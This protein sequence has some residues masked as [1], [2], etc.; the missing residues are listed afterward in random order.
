[1]APIGLPFL[2]ALLLVGLVVSL[3]IWSRRRAR[4]KLAAL[5]L[6]AAFALVQYAALSD[7]LSRPKPIE[8]AW[9]PPDPETSAVVAN[10]MRE[11]EAIFIWLVEEG[12]M[13]PRALQLP[14]SEEMARQLHEASRKSE[15][16]GGTLR[17][18][19]RK[20]RQL[21]EGH[22]VF[23]AEPQKS[24]PPKHVSGLSGGGPSLS[25]GD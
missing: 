5:G 2:A 22:R 18:R 16:T 6:L 8:L 4:F 24:P 25:S 23:Y 13:E 21:V 10:V 17:M 7:L 11:G 14:W 19:Y 12:A 3:A 20:S 15:E 1:M 9:S